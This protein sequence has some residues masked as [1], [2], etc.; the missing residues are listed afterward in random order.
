MRM[1]KMRLEDAIVYV[2]A[3]AGRGY[4]TAEIARI[5]NQNEIH[6]RKD[7]RPV[8]IAQVYAVVMRNPSIFTKDGGI[9]HLIM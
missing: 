9:I 3:C 4:T 8:T 1:L 5:I 6:L 7:G 2:L